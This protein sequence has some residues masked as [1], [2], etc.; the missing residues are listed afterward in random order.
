MSKCQEKKNIKADAGGG[1]DKHQP[2]INGCWIKEAL[3][4][5]KHKA[6]SNDT[7]DQN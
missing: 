3:D 4:G 7:N 6:T 5:L 1:N 2:T